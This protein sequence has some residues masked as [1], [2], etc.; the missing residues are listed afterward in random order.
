[1]STATE[2]QSTVCHLHL[3]FCI[4][5]FLSHFTDSV[6]V[7]DEPLW[8]SK[9][10]GIGAFKKTSIKKRKECV[11]CGVSTIYVQDSGDALNWFTEKGKGFYFYFSLLLWY[12]ENPF[13]ALV[14]PFSSDVFV[15]FPICLEHGCLSWLFTFLP[16][17]KWLCTE[18]WEDQEHTKIWARVQL[19]LLQVG[20][21]FKQSSPILCAGLGCSTLRLELNWDSYSYPSK[22]GIK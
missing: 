9:H 2:K 13:I 3:P 15:I 1:M 21:I 20:G 8:T 7:T 11:L 6:P 22:T 14:F 17:S 18:L 16:Y 4:Q 5:P 19:Q 12:W 10:P